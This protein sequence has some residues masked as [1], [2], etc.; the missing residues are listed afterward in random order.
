MSFTHSEYR[1][2][3]GAL[4]AS[5]RRLVTVAE[6]LGAGDER[7]GFVIIRHDVDRRPAKALE[8]A[9]LER[10]LGVRSTYYFRMDRYGRFPVI[11]LRSIGALGHEVGYHYETLSACSG[12]LRKALQLFERN[13]AELR[14]SV[15]CL[16]VSMHGAPLSRHDNRALADHI[17]FARLG[18]LGDAVRHIAPDAPFYF[19]DTGGLWS[20]QGVANL[21]D[22]VGRS[23][24]PEV[25]PGNGRKFA[26]FLAEADAAIYMSTHPERWCR[27]RADFLYS[28]AM[29]RLATSGKHALAGCRT[30]AKHVSRLRKPSR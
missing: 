24:P 4:S 5:G 11:E 17:D 22:R 27:T 18:L 7:R 3:L 29:D 8:L 13:L 16:T 19:T 15:A 10:S 20:V 23:P 26:E 9:A 12:D 30:L 21:R 28:A 6:Y 1:D 14:K 25:I 2:L